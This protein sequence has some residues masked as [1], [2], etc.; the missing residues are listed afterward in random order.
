MVGIVIARIQLVLTSPSSQREK[1]VPP[2]GNDK[3]SQAV[4]AL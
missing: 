1:R 3:R 4:T 2:K